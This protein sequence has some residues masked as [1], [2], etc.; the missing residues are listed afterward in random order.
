M[1]RSISLLLCIIL[2]TTIMPFQIFAQSYTPWTEWTTT[3]PG[4]KDGREIETRNTVTGHNL[5]L[6]L[7]KNAAT[8]AR[9]Y[10]SYSVN[11]NYGSYGLNSYYGE[12][13]YTTY[14]SKAA[15]NAADKAVEGAYVNYAANTAGYNKGRGTALV[16]WGVQDCL[17]WFIASD[18]TQTEYRY[19]DV[20]EETK[21][22]TVKFL[23]WDDSILKQETVSEGQSATA[24][25]NPT[26][27]G[28][29]FTGWSAPFDNIKS[30][31]IVKALYSSK[32]KEY[33]VSFLDWD[34]R[35]LK[36]EKVQEG[37]SANPPQ[38]P[39]REGYEFVGWSLPFDAVYSD[40]TINANYKPVQKTFEVL[41]LDW[42]ERV[43]KKET[44][45]EGESATPPPNPTREG[46]KFDGW[47]LPFENVKENI[48]TQAKYVR[49]QSASGIGDFSYSFGNSSYSFNYP[50]NYRIP[51]ERF[52]LMFGNSALAQT[53]YHQDGLWGGNCF[54]MA[55]TSSMFYTKNM[56]L[57]SFNPQAGKIG[58]L[59]ISDKNNNLNLSVRDYIEAMQISQYDISIQKQISLSGN[60]IQRIYEETERFSLTGASPIIIGVFGMIG[61]SRSGHALLPYKVENVS[62]NQSRIYVYDCNFPNQIRYITLEKDSSGN[63][64]SWH[65]RL[66]D[67]YNWGSKYSRPW[68]TYYNYQTFF[69]VWEKRGGAGNMVLLTLNVDNCQILDESNQLV[70]SLDNGE[71]KTS[72]SN[73]YRVNYIRATT[74]GEAPASSN[75][76]WLPA[77]LYQISS[78]D[79]NTEL[80]LT[81]SDVENSISVNTNSSNVTFAVEDKSQ[82]NYVSINEPGC[83]YEISMLSSNQAEDSKMEFKGKTL[84][85]SLTLLKQA[86]QLSVNNLGSEAV[87]TQNGVD[88]TEKVMKL[89]SSTNKMDK[90]NTK[91]LFKNNL[92]NEDKANSKAGF[93]DVSVKDWFYE[94]VQKAYAMG[95]INGKSKTQF[96]PHDNITYAEVIKLAACMNQ[97]YFNGEVTLKQAGKNWYDSYVEYAK[98]NHIID[99]NFDGMMNEDID[100]KTYVSI[101]AKAIPVGL[102][103]PVINDIPD[104]AIPD[105]K[106]GDP[107]YKDIYDF[108][109]KGIVIGVD[110][111]GSFTPS[112]KI[113]RSEIAA[114]LIRLMDKDSR[115][116]VNFKK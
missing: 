6:F 22:Y 90:L 13:H 69:N 4:M 50:P 75:A 70:A 107:Y 94:S 21:T 66:N 10:R 36:T 8:G 67:R 76:I 24:P 2:L 106:V 82:T 5:V 7:T 80:R 100:R 113:K 27:E 58:D 91:D 40:L 44:V 97:L 14:I 38:N 11:G 35:V 83:D 48:T 46:Y 62:S 18:V 92:K 1:K 19:R 95:L 42:D 72:Y 25:P 105:V 99:K 88:I 115:V 61:P 43:L 59:S 96:K 98:R 12:H 93:E 108:Y 31:T 3:H 64:I 110:K 77:N 102:D 85:E 73:I 65:Y 20:I 116:K 29:N 57:N 45:K 86:D 56:M 53:F 33:T 55:S 68:I 71:L 114:I 51:Y 41:F 17:V 87:I 9:E 54:G 39:V 112:E 23:D 78:K 101:F 111:E 15:A 37:K 81:L 52:A 16:G 74:D 30:D 60:D 28:Y 47:S 109:R 104:N 26:R 34:G 63:F 103:F 79:E 32:N 89:N 49:A 84:K